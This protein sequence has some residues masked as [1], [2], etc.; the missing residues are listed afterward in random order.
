MPAFRINVGFVVNP[1]M[2]GSRDNASMLARSA[3]SAKT[4]TWRCSMQCFIG[5]SV[6]VV[7]GS[8]RRQCDGRQRA[9]QQCVD[10]NLETE[11]RGLLDGNTDEPDSGSDADPVPAR[12]PRRGAHVAPDGNAEKHDDHRGR[13]R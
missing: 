8:N 12:L 1:L 4:L 2:W 6:R 5:S 13:N 10:G 3:P 7:I 9:E 11:L